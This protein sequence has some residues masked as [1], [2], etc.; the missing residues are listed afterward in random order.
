MGWAYPGFQAAL[1]ILRGCQTRILYREKH[2]SIF[3]TNHQEVHMTR[4]YLEA[5]RAL[6]ECY[7]EEGTQ[8]KEF[9]G[10]GLI[11]AAHP[12]L[13]PMAYNGKTWDEVPG[14]V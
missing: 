14:L 1:P 3:A 6:P 8:V 7:V 12:N 5:I 10:I 9:L 13:V 11:V 4:R 2:A